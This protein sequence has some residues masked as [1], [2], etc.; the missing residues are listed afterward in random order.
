MV[1]QKLFQSNQPQKLFQR[2][3]EEP[4]EIRS[5]PNHRPHKLVLDNKQEI[6][7]KC[8]EELYERTEPMRQLF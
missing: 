5:Q 2:S 8:C 3:W 1:S 6:H 7:L 4:K